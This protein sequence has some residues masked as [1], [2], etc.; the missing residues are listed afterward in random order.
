VKPEQIQVTDICG[1]LV[2]GVFLCVL[3]TR[4]GWPLWQGEGKQVKI[5]AKPGKPIKV[6]APT[7]KPEPTEQQGDGVSAASA[8]AK[9]CDR[10][11]SKK[12]R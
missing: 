5:S 6:I 10:F 7:P 9:R 1:R 3:V 11:A 12:R 8:S 4:E 2:F